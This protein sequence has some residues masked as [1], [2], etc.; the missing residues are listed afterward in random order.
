MPEFIWTIFLVDMSGEG[1]G[2]LVNGHT[3]YVQ[4]FDQFRVCCYL[5]LVRLTEEQFMTY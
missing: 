4:R 2:D 5:K 3:V 1:S